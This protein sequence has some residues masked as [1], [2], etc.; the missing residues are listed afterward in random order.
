MRHRIFGLLLALALIASGTSAQQD[1]IRA[2]LVTCAPGSAIYELYGHTAIRV[3]NLTKGIDIVYNYGAFDFDSPHFIWR[4]LKGETDYLLAVQRWNSFLEDYMLRGSA[5]YLQD[6]NL[7]QEESYRLAVLLDM[8]AMPE[9]RVYRYDFL[10]N[11]C[12]TMA[13]DKVEEALEGRVRYNIT[14]CNESFRSILHEYNG[15]EPWSQFGVDMV[16][17]GEADDSITVRETSFAPFRL[18]HLAANTEIADTSAQSRPLVSN[19]T[20]ILP[21][22]EVEF[23]H[24]IISP[25]QGMML[26]FLIV[27]LICCI[28]WNMKKKFCIV[29]IILLS[30]QGIAGIVITFLYFFSSHPT[31]TTNWLIIPLNPIPLLCIP[32]VVR[33]LKSNCLDWYM[34]FNF[35]I[36]VLFIIFSSRIPQYISAGMIALLATFALRSLGNIH[37]QIVNKARIRM[38]GWRLPWKKSVKSAVMLLLALLPMSAGAQSVRQAP[39]LVVGIVVDQLDG[40]YVRRLM[41]LFGDD[42][43]RRF[44]YH[45]YNITGAAFEYEASDRASSVASIYT[46]TTP[47]YHG[48]VGERW[49]ERKNLMTVRA[50]NDNDVIGVNTIDRCSPKNL[51]VMT[52]TDQMKIVSGGG[53]I[54]CSIAADAD[55]AIY[56]GGHDADVVLWMN[57]T[58]GKWSTSSY[59]GDVPAWAVNTGIDYSW[60]PSLPMAYYLNSGYNPQN[61]S[62]VRNISDDEISL[63]K[64]SP[65][66]N[67]KVIDLAVKAVDAMDLGVSGAPDFLAV[68]LYAGGFNHQPALLESI[69]VQDTYARLDQDIATLIG[70]IEEKLGTGSVLF[71]LTS[72][73][74]KEDV[75]P[76]L[77]NPRMPAGTVQMERVTA[78]LNL[79]LSAIY[80][81]GEYISTYNGTNLYLDMDLI[82]RHDIKIHEIYDHCVDVLLQMEGIKG[83]FTQRDL[84]S[85][86]LNQEDKRKRDALNSSCS[87][88]LILEVTPGWTVSDDKHGTKH[89]EK[90]NRMNFPVMFYGA[91][92]SPDIDDSEISASVLASTVSWILGIPAPGACSTLPMTKFW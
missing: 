35:T 54:V 20:E 59:Y 49:V 53:S 5:V 39:K 37:Y 42:G 40:E 14:T 69:E 12:A 21:E 7:T 56:A 82:K 38:R 89:V 46:G 4:W 51:Q 70:H 15:K 30:V 73:G 64:T 11:N 85:S 61:R 75:T 79:Y 31:V 81:Q 48:I 52:I 84:V 28:E 32:A 71:F 36:L 57:D 24:R 13:L 26:L 23:P 62:F 25:A 66:A 65:I 58:D 86:N 80:P 67:R 87:G 63:E 88:D 16:L 18:M 90:R 77:Y 3:T 92:V 10:R 45:G 76:E 9:N 68:S 8:N 41:P 19:F 1:S 91:G 72:T 44:W 29:D 60:K 27:L 74:Y 78:L 47:F 43:F 22:H 34:F 83:V 6:L 50:V 55:A 2:T 33:N 17:G